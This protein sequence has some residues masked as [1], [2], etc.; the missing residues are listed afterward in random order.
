LDSVSRYSRFWRVRFNHDRARSNVSPGRLT[1]ASGSEH[2]LLE[3]LSQ[4]HQPCALTL[5]A[6]P[7]TRR[8]GSKADNPRRGR[9]PAVRRMSR[10]RVCQFVEPG[11]HDLSYEYSVSGTQTISSAQDLQREV[12]SLNSCPRTKSQLFNLSSAQSRR[13]GDDDSGRIQR[14]HC[15]LWVPCSAGPGQR[16][17]H[18]LLRYM[19]STRRLCANAH[20]GGSVQSRIQSREAWRPA[21]TQL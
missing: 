17:R 6:V 18:F 7:S 19:P 9:T 15:L 11:L 10:Q 2:R 16:P 5:S 3:V 12:R 1:G 13:C 20:A 14:T 8:H 4:Q 21:E